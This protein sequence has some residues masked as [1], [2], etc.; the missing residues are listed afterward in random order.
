MA[1]LAFGKS[2]FTK[3]AAGAAG[4]AEHG[5]ITGLHGD[6]NNSSVGFVATRVRGLGNEAVMSGSV[7]FRALEG[8]FGSSKEFSFIIGGTGNNDPNRIFE[9]FLNRKGDGDGD[10]DDHSIVLAVKY[11]NGTRSVTSFKSGSD[12]FTSNA[13][14]D[15]KVLDGKW[16]N[17][18]FVFS[19]TNT[20]R[21]LLLDGVDINNG[22]TDGPGDSV[23]GTVTMGESNYS[24]TNPPQTSADDGMVFYHSM[25]QGIPG[26]FGAA[27]DI[28]PFWFYNQ[29][30]DFSNASTLAQ[31]Y[32]SSNTDGYVTA[33]SDGRTGGAAEAEL[34]ITTDG[35]SISNGGSLSSSTMHEVGTVT[36]SNSTN[37][38]GSGSTRTSA[39]T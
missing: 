25:Q 3:A 37:G 19:G 14:F 22:R 13:D 31:Y 17:I 21:Q 24:G 10:Q 34:F 15:S 33:G 26:G 35:S 4:G 12:F 23:T 2:V 27:F 28:G 9:L 16:H 38:P 7:W 30:I 39:N 20:E 8:D 11:T 36:K 32:N 18:S 5:F 1:P 6:P 29:I